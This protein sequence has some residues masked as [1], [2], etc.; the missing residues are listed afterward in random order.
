VNEKLPE[1][2]RFDCLDWHLGK[3]QRLHREFKRLYP[4]GP[5]WFRAR[6]VVG[7]M[8]VCLVVSEWGFGNFVR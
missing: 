1:M 2:D 3:F 6:L 5:L 8:F 7:L 4:E